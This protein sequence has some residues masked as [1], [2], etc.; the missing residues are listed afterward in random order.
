MADGDRRVVVTGMGALTPLGNDVASTWE[1][2]LAGRADVRVVV[3]LRN[4]G[5]CQGY[6]Q[7][8]EERRR[9]HKLAD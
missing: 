8:D 9:A 3:R 7:P 5:Q 2:M 1:A 6:E 4:A